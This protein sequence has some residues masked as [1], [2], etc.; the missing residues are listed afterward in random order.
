MPGRT[1]TS[2]WDNAGAP[3]ARRYTSAHTHPPGAAPHTEGR[4]H[5]GVCARVCVCARAREQDRVRSRMPCARRC[6]LERGPASVHHVP[7]NYTAR[8]RQPR[9]A[10]HA[11]RRRITTL[12]PPIPRQC[13]QACLLTPTPWRP[14]GWHTTTAVGGT[15]W[16]RNCNVTTTSACSHAPCERGP[17]PEQRHGAQTA[18]AAGP[19][20]D[21]RCDL[22]V[23]KTTRGSAVRRA[24][25]HMPHG[26][27][28]AA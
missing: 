25:G 17:R 14:A 26:L 27:A 21:R 7:R 16:P 9:R 19:T 28:A 5:T 1:H 8:D 12:V 10:P 4:L 11:L 2:R 23:A 20:A 22:V 15:E 24:A 3:C 18:V 13:P 6:G